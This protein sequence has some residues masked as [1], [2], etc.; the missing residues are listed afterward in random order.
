MSCMTRSMEVARALI[1]CGVGKGTRVGILMTN[2]LE[3][4]SATFGTALAGGVVTTISTFFTAPELD[5]VLKA[6]GISVLLME[7]HVLKKDFT[8]MIGELEPE[9]ST[10]APG[11]VASIR[12]PFLR[13]VAMVDDAPGGGAFEGW[14]TFLDRGAA[15]APELVLAAA[16]TCCPQRSGGAVFLVRLYR[17]S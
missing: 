9:V 7:R 6:S 12:Y 17:Q 16:D 5:V 2:R 14:A 4:L 8:A 11:S 1:A 10:A 3:F 15:V 13:H